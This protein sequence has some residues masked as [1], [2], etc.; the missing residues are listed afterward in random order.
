MPDTELAN[1]QRGV[2]PMTLLIR[3]CLAILLI[4]PVPALAQNI[5]LLPEGNTLV[6]LSVTERVQVPQDLLLATLRIESEDPNPQVLQNRIN[7]SMEQ[8]LQIA[9]AV[10]DIKVSTGHYSVYQY[11][12][13]PQG[14]RADNVWR[15]SQSLT[16][17]GK[18]AQKVLS[19]TGELQGIGL[20]ISQLTYQLSTERA[21]E[22]RDSLVE[23]AIS[24]ATEKL[25]RV[26]QAMGK[27]SID[28][29][30]L[31]IESSLNYANSMDMLSARAVMMEMATPVAEAG[32]TEVTLTVRVQ[33]VA[34]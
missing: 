17:E 30:T 31:D 20:V 28:I 29:A 34:R 11:N 18:D 24:R 10:A 23:T 32:E 1:Q 14:G 22:V 5:N 12:R 8:A 16:L 6:T 27:T 9:R 33:A 26:A 25:E 15:G 21:D 13:Q 7:T 2:P 4:L 19:L 3:F